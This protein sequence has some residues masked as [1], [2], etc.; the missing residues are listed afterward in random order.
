MDLRIS[1]WV[2]KTVH[3]HDNAGTLTTNPISTGAQVLVGTLSGTALQ[4]SI[5]LLQP[6]VALRYVGLPCGSQQLTLTAAQWLHQ[7]HEPEW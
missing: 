5:V 4:A 7:Q 2:N 1:S 3:F 6:D